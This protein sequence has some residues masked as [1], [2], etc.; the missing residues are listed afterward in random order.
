M[1]KLRLY[2]DTSVWNFYYADD[3]PEKMEITKQFFENL[4]SGKYQ[5]YSSGVVVREIEDADEKTVSELVALMKEYIPIMLEINDEIDELADIYIAEGVISEKKRDDALHI[6]IAT[7]NE[8]DALVS[9]NYR[10]LANLNKKEKVHAVNIMQG[11][12]KELEMITPMEV[13]GDE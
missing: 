7:V 9:W 5:I 13:I 3:V 2:L 8:M 4:K 11:Y 6:A 12:L 10:H 1:R